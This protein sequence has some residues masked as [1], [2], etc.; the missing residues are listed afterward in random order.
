[1]PGN[2][3]LK[4]ER[5]PKRN[6]TTPARR[7]LK[8]ERP[9]YTRIKRI[10]LY[11]RHVAVKPFFTELEALPNDIANE[12][13]LRAVALG[14]DVALGEARVKVEQRRTSGREPASNALQPILLDVS[15]TS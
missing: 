9:I 13:L 10:S 11:R 2:N 1:M 3:G 8:L 15:G 6:T 7:T 14:A 4:D 12:T 5:M